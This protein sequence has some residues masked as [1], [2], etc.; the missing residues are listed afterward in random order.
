[1]S[2]TT[3]SGLNDSAVSVGQAPDVGPLVLLPPALAPRHMPAKDLTKCYAAIDGGGTKTE[4]VVYVP[5]GPICFARTGP[6]NPE[7]YGT[8]EATA[9]ILKALDLAIRAA[10]S[11]SSVPLPPLGAVFAGISGLDAADEC[12]VL[13]AE[14]AKSAGGAAVIAMNDIVS[15]WATAL[16]CGPGVVVISGTGSNCLGVDLTGSTWRTGGWGHLFADEGSG[17]LIGLDGLRAVFQWRDGRARPTALTQL[18]LDHF[19]VRSVLALAKAAYHRPLD[20]SEIAG[21]AP[22][23][24][25]AASDGDI[26]AG[27]VYAKAAADMAGLVKTARSHLDLLGPNFDLGLVGGNIEKSALFK[28]LL[29]KELPEARQVVSSSPPCTGGLLLAAKLGGEWPVDPTKVTDAVGRAYGAW[30][31]HD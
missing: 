18:A 17:Y 22:S 3:S 30:R 27:E 13:G 28:Q 16:Q 29:A 19:E 2:T 25:R 14:L 8:S 31:S 7:A 1:M 6:G 5:G 9:N 15:A 26:S 21:F 11:Q 4:A 12:A 24:E 23:V 10:D 20:K